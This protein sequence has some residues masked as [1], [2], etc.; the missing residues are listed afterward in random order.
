MDTVGTIVLFFGKVFIASLTG[1][2]CYVMLIKIDYFK[3]E[4]YSPV[5]PTVV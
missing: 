2:I 1:L 5:V 4:I 3:T